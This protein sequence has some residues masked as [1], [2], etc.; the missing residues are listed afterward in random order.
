MKIEELEDE[1]QQLMRPPQEPRCAVPLDDDDLS[2]GI[3][4]PIRKAQDAQLVG[5]AV[6]GGGIRSATFNLG[7]LQRLADADLLRQVDY[8]SAV[9]GGSYIA[10]WLLAWA[11]RQD[12]GIRRVQRWI[13]PIR[14]PYPDAI[15]TEPI[16]FLRRYSNYLAPKGGFLSADSWT[17]VSIWIRNAILNQLVIVLFL[18]ALILLPRSLYPLVSQI[19]ADRSLFAG[20]AVLLGAAAAL[21]GGHLEWFDDSTKMRPGVRK[22]GE[23]FGQGA[24]QRTIILALISVAFLVSCGLFSIAHSPVHVFAPT[25]WLLAST[26]IIAQLF[27]NSSGCFYTGDPGPSKIKLALAQLLLLSAAVVSALLGAFLMDRLVLAVSLT[28]QA[29]LQGRLLVF[30][31]PVLLTVLTAVLIFYIGLLGVNFPDERREWWGRLGAWLLIYSLAWCAICTVAIYAPLWFLHVKRF[32]WRVVAASIW[33]VWTAA[34]VKIG[35]SRKTPSGSGNQPDTTVPW[36]DWIARLSPYVFIAGV[37]VWI[38]IGLQSILLSYQH[39]NMAGDVAGDWDRL[40]TKPQQLPFVLMISALVAAILLAWR[41][42]VNEFSMHH[43]YKNRLMRCYLGATRDPRWRSPNP[44][45]GFDNRDDI[46]L[47]DFVSSATQTDNAELKKFLGP[48]L[49]VNTSLNLVAGKELA[50]QERKAESFVF[51]PLYCGYEYVD[52]NSQLTTSVAHN[53]SSFW[54]R[55]ISW[56]SDAESARWS[57]LGFRPTVRFAGPDRGVRLATAVAISGAAANPNMGYHSSPALTFLMTLFNVRLGW[58]IGNTRHKRTWRRWSPK[59]GLI[60]LLS[61]LFGNTSDGMAYVNLSDGGHFEN[62]GIYELIRRHC[63]FVVACDAEEDRK[64]TFGGLGNVVRKCRT[65][66]GVEIVLDVERIRTAKISNEREVHWVV[67]KI[68]YPD[69][70][71]GKLLYIKSS[72]TGDEQVDVREYSWRA[73]EFPHQTTADQFFNESQFESYRALGYH[74]FGTLP[75]LDNVGSFDKLFGNATT[76]PPA[77]NQGPPNLTVNVMR[78]LQRS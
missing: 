37:F 63:S 62:L 65:D 20:I 55:W 68:T 66:F 1:L 22:S 48:Y 12:D 56:E 10:S 25:F 7:V 39:T 35:T 77:V 51:A 54:K 19:S 28:E 14:S 38:S 2:G 60:Y 15:E 21:I 67:G 33:T 61:E 57:D 78:I 34:G 30:G 59:L 9:S 50:W 8:V 29:A 26:L 47:S 64:F 32:E 11:K 75:D 72:L 43:Y 45:T 36:F 44:F 74:V 3:P 4:S 76:Q 69:G 42:D 27:G 24:I 18:G 17:G 58:W 31:V 40:A 49:L 13:S 23:E 6:S 73:P 46:H 41:F 53:K 5:L 16:R 70:F 52:T 71:V